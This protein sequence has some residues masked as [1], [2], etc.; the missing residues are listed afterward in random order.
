MKPGQDLIL[1]VG[2]KKISVICRLD[3]QVEIE[4]YR[5]GGILHTVLLNFIRDNQ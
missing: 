3:T 2:E 1:Q 4:Y 5:N